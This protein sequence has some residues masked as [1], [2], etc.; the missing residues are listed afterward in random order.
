MREHLPLRQW[1]LAAIGVLLIGA[2]VTI[3]WR[4]RAPVRTAHAAPAP[5]SV[6]TAIHV[7]HDGPALRLHWSPDSLA[8]RRARSGAV[9][10]QDGTRESRMELTP[11][12]LR[13]GMAA[14]WPD[15]PEVTFRLELDG[16]PAGTIRAWSP[17][18]EK[19][20]SP[21]ASTER[22]RKRGAAIRRVQAAA[23]PPPYAEEPK[24]ESA[25]SRAIGKIPLLRR[26][27]ARHD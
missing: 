10:I 19:R 22:P 27:R 8:V 26:L 11:R 5:S 9:V 16:A 25:L 20:P 7:Q 13:A 24:R 14:Y 15:S 17:V 1:L 21:F 3:A 12:D 2:A 23:V 18:E 6:A 4:G